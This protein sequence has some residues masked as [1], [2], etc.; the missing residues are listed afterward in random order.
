MAG[1]TQNNELVLTIYNYKVPGVGEGAQLCYLVKKGSGSKEI[2]YDQI[3]GFDYQWGYNYTIIVERKTNKAPMADAS[4]FNYKLKK[5]LKK[6]KAP[7]AERF[8]LRLR[9][10]DQDLI[11]T[12]NGKCSYFGEIEI[13]PGT[14]KCADVARAESAIFRHAGNRPGLVLVGLK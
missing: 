11:Q 14:K 1:T 2:F 10:N 5:I 3:E 4:S 13:Y 8:E 7:V 9:V 6:E 12:R